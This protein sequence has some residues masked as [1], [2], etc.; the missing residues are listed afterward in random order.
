MAYTSWS[1]GYR[2]RKFC[3][4]SP[5]C[6][7]PPFALVLRDLS[8]ICQMFFL[9]S[10][11]SSSVKFLL[12]LK[13]ARPRNRAPKL[14]KKK[15]RISPR[16]Q[17]RIQKKTQ[18]KKTKNTRKEVLFGCF[19]YVLVFLRNLG[20]GLGGNFPFFFRVL[21]LA[22][23]D[24]CS[25]WAFRNAGKFCGKFGGNFARLFLDCHFFSFLGRHLIRSSD[26][27]PVFF[28]SH[29]ARGRDPHNC[30]LADFIFVKDRTW[31]SEK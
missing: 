9:L 31:P 27:L 16:G 3:T 5:P 2:P 22:V 29:L 13:N 20:S 23:L 18:K 15:L 14:L 26:I 8:S 10:C 7:P 25:L 4:S 30:N 28:M 6:D 17:P 11:R 12:S 24:P 21:V 19:K 1:Q